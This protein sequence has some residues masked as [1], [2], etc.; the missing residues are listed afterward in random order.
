MNVLVV[1]GLLA[2][3]FAMTGVRETTQPADELAGICPAPR[4]SPAA[5]FG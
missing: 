3:V 1:Q 5:R 2:A 4:T